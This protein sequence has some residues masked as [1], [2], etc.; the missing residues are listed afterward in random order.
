MESIISVY[1]NQVTFI[2]SQTEISDTI[3]SNDLEEKSNF[4]LELNY[5]MNN[6]IFNLTL[7]DCTIVNLPLDTNYIY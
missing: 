2:P 4:I 5:P 7:D 1:N 6:S 3:C